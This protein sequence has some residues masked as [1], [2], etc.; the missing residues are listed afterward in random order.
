MKENSLRLD[1]YDYDLPEERIAKHPLTQR[2]QSK[3][4]VYQSGNITDRHF[5]NLPDLLPANSCLC[6][7][8]TQV[9]PA[10]LF[11]R[12]PAN[13]Q[14]PG[15]LIEVLLL[16]PIK[17]STM[18]SEAMS[19][20]HSVTWECMIGNLRKWKSEQVLEQVFI[21]N[22]REITLRAK[23][24]DSTQKLVQFHWD[25]DITFAELAKAAG[26]VPLPPT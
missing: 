22:D 2:D 9:I 14:G 15:A 8:N 7:N 17:P 1:F 12:K 10:R 4:L 5:Y 16:H 18:M 24:V 26:K 19:T 13:E 21:D 11:F 20:H 3:L 6:F 25:A 23:L